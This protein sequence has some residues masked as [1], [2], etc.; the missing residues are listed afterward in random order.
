MFAIPR[1]WYT[2]GGGD[3][4]VTVLVGV[5]TSTSLCDVDGVWPLH[6]PLMYLQ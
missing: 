6:T 1:C 4:D 2:Q 5:S 3:G